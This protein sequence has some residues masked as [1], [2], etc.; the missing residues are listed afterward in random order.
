MLTHGAGIE[1]ADWGA[2]FDRIRAW[3]LADLPQLV[4]GYGG[5]GLRHGRAR[6]PIHG[7]DNPRAVSVTAGKGWHGHTARATGGDG[8]DL[9]RGM[10]FAGLPQGQGRLAALL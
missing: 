2:D 7:G 5:V 3:A 1:A 4:A 10:C 9:V 6:Y 8:V